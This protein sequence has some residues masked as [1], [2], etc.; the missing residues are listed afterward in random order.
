[1]L[2]NQTQAKLINQ[3]FLAM[4]SFVLTSCCIWLVLDRIE[5]DKND[6]SDYKEVIKYK[7]KMI[8][9]TRDQ[10]AISDQIER[11]SRLLKDK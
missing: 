6:I 7:D 1:M 2:P 9:D 8:E 11:A 4:Y 5:H 3:Y 10:K